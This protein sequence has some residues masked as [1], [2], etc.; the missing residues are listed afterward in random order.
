MYHRS[1]ISRLSQ[2]LRFIGLFVIAWIVLCAPLGQAQYQP[3]YS[4]PSPIQNIPQLPSDPQAPPKAPW[5]TRM[6][7]K[8]EPPP[9]ESEII[10]VGPRHYDANPATMLRL[11]RPI[12]LKTP[13]GLQRVSPGFYLS[14]VE[15]DTPTPQHTQTE[16]PE[17]NTLSSED[18]TLFIPDEKTGAIEH[19]QLILLRGN[20]TIGTIP[21]VDQQALPAMPMIQAN[22]QATPKS[23]QLIQDANGFTRIQVDVPSQMA[24]WFS[25]P[26]HC[27]SATQRF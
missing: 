2:P 5:L 14:R 13:Q 20:Q 12:C 3:R 6:F 19:G 10:E 4:Q 1:I 21:L 15:W 18:A 26:C 23:A 24:S 8:K 17:L 27:P 9:K 7:T 22:Q 25:E 16:G 11:T